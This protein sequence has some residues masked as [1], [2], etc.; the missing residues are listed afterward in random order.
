MRPLKKLY[1]I[2]TLTK[3]TKE[4]PKT[5]N[6]RKV[7]KENP[8]LIFSS[9]RPRKKNQQNLNLYRTS[10][11]KLTNTSCLINSMVKTN[12]KNI[13]CEPSKPKATKVSSTASPNDNQLKIHSLHIH[14]QNP[15]ALQLVQAFHKFLQN[16]NPL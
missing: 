6:F 4:P 1:K 2:L 15:Q 10:P 11:Q 12:K 3:P 7:L 8:H 14:T 9:I 5:F 16:L 13:H